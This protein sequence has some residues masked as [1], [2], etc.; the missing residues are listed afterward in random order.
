MI[1]FKWDNPFSDVFLKEVI[2]VDK[3]SFFSN[4]DLCEQSINL[5]NDTVDW[6]QMYN[7][8]QAQSRIFD[9]NEVCF[10]LTHNGKVLGH[11]WFG[12]MWWYNIFVHPSRPE[13]LTLDFC[14]HCFREVNQKCFYGWTDYWNIKATKLFLKTGAKIL[15]PFKRM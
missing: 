10:I 7:L 8:D 1:W 5:F 2:R 12:E 6:P 14:F 4:K 3:N 11:T 9:N 13:G 15:H